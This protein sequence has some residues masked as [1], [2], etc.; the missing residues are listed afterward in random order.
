MVGRMKNQHG[1]HIPLSRASGPR[2]AARASA[3]PSA[4]APATRAREA[5]PVPTHE[6]VRA[7]AEVLWRQQGCPEGRNVEI[8]LEAERQ[9]NRVAE[10]ARMARHSSV[11]S[12]PLSR[13]DPKSDDVMGELEELFPDRALGPSALAAAISSERAAEQDR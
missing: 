8:W 10:Q 12:T 6:E 4:E 1:G 7:G 11:S 3:L 5:A 13:L 2:G 9:L